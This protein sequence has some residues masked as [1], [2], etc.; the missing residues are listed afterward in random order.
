M[1]ESVPVLRTFEQ[2]MGVKF[3]SLEELQ[4]QGAR[5]E[6]ENQA[7]QENVFCGFQLFR[8][9]LNWKIGAWLASLCVKN[10]QQI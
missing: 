9:N 1:K 8:M 7:N 6:E 10:I 5:Q 2:T 3:W 4:N